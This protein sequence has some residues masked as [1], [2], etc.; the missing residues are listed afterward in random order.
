M[1]IAIVGAGPAGATAATRLVRAGGSV[2]LFDPSHPREKPCGGGLTGRALRLFCELVDMATLPALVS[3]SVVVET[4]ASGEPAKVDLV[5]RG[6]SLLRSLVVVSREIF[7]RALVE[8]AVR[9]GARFIPKKVID[10]DRHAG[11]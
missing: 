8:A 3:H 1:R 11:L 10:V 2:L 9:S 7:D 5:V 4:P 6:L